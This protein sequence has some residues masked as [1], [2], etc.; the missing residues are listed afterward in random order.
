[1]TRIVEI[2]RRQL[3]QTRVIEE[4][5]TALAEGE[6]QL[7]VRR[8]ALTANNV[9]LAMF[10]HSYRYW[11]F[12]PSGDPEWGRVPVWG[13]AE[14]ESS[15]HPALSRG[16]ALYGFLPMAQSV[17][18][19][20]DRVG[21]KRLVDAA[22]HRADLPAVYQSYARVPYSEIDAEPCLRPLLHPLALTAFLLAL[23]VDELDPTGQR[24]VVFTSAS[25][26]TALA[27]ALLCRRAARG[28]Q[29]RLIGLSSPQNTAFV[30][31]R[32][33]FDT[34]DAYGAA[35]A[36]VEAGAIVID[37][38]GNAGHVASL[39]TQLGSSARLLQIGMT[40]WR[41]AG[42]SHGMPAEVFFAPSEALR[43]IETWGVA[44]YEQRFA[45]AWQ[46]ILDFA[47]PWIQLHEAEGAAAMV[48]GWSA[49][50]AGRVA[51]DRGLLYRW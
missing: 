47:Q 7:V 22:V 21:A 23:R 2:H 11:D 17:R 32:A 14:V 30:A 27:T 20:P 40:D 34:A 37:F 18:L 38:A 26:K 24:P 39:A 6:V 49:L 48:E 28:Q 19:R 15:A 35:L 1:M 51:P 8:F 44:E 5:Q 33:L 12:F 31:A 45:A 36:G 25:S 41:A 4:A 9:T 42:A 43:W 50:L 13:Y 46:A 16:D 29:R 10:G 3:A